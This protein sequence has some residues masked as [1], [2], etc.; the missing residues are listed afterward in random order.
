[1]SSWRLARSLE[2]LRSQINELHPNRSKISDGTI[3]D[4]LHAKVKSEHNPNSEGVV[5]AL[6]LTH[7]PKHLDCNWLAEVLTQ[8]G[9][10]RI[11]YVIWNRR[12]WEG[13]WK[14]Y[15][16]ANPHDKHLHLSVK[17]TKASY[18]NAS[19]W[20]LSKKQGETFMVD[21][22]MLNNLYTAVFDR[23]PD[24]GAKGWLGQPPDV[25]L[26]KLLE[27]PEYQQ[28]MAKIRKALESQGEYV[29]APQL[30]IKK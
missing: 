25:V 24:A 1:M 30:F 14:A 11:W 15:K 10:S 20:N 5:T 28:R 29:P 12:I 2:T 6:D 9:D 18:D 22:N 8:S 4:F 7:D 13:S 26:Q 17:Q 21:Q 23:Q 16:G 27:S 3:G 19:K